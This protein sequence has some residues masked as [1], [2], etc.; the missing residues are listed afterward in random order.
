MAISLKTTTSKGR[1]YYSIVEN[2]RVPGRKNP[3]TETIYYIGRIDNLIELATLRETVQQGIENSTRVIR[4]LE[5]GPGAALWAFTEELGLPSMINE[6]VAKTKGLDAGQAFTVLTINRL[7]DPQAKMGIRDWIETTTLPQMIDVPVEM[8]NGETICNLMD[9]LTED[10]CLAI[11]RAR[12]E[13]ID[14]ISKQGVAHYD[15]TSSYTYGRLNKMAEKGYSRDHRPDLEQVNWGLVVDQNMTPITMEMHAGNLNDV[16]QCV[17]T[18][19]KF[20]EQVGIEDFTLVFDR[21]NVSETN[22]QAVVEGMGFDVI[23]TMRNRDRVTREAIDAA[24]KLPQ[25]VLKS[26]KSEDGRKAKVVGASV[27]MPVYG[28]LRKMVVCFNESTFD[29]RRSNREKAL[30]KA[31]RQLEGLRTSMATTV[32]SAEEAQNKIEEILKPVKKMI[33][34]ELTLTGLHDTF[35]FEL[36]DRGE[37]K[38]EKWDR[39]RA[40]RRL[41]K[42]QSDLAARKKRKAKPEWIEKK[43]GELLHKH[44]GWFEV[45]LV[46]KARDLTVIWE[47][48]EQAIERKGEWDGW[49]VL[50]ASNIEADD[51]EIVE[52]YAA[53]DGVEKSFRTI[54]NPIKVRPLNHHKA[55]R[56]RAHIWICVLA[57]VIEKLFMLKLKEAEPAL[58][59]LSFAKV[60]KLLRPIRR[61]YIEIDIGG[62]TKSFW[63]TNEL[64][65]NQKKVLEVFTQPNSN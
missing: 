4:S 31:E 11:D 17:P 18:L 44:P 1:K 36:M 25:K 30:K 51:R 65:P 10:V 40:R 3:V 39:E 19:S 47:R 23:C 42:F 46:R 63:K 53:Q 57:H 43:L 50:M 45:E 37:T 5:H 32:H 35:E 21:G 62:E 22:I 14:A 26:S 60:L 9:Y 33:T 38:A 6:H 61:S 27:V 20:K 54:K 24:R 55:Q 12:F 7:I 16:S 49:Y 13:Q 48:D 58:A 34:T 8:L 29:T 59:K 15:I 64:T 56:V 52:A 28:E 41:E 2:K